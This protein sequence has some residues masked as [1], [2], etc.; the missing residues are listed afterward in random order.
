[1]VIAAEVAQHLP[2]WKDY[3]QTV[4]DPAHLLAEGTWEAVTA[5]VF[6]RPIWRFFH[7]KM[8]KSH[9]ITHVTPSTPA[10]EKNVRVIHFEGL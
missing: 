10:S 7:K 8:D 9:N 3:L 1:M 2:L 5:L 6:A 4:A